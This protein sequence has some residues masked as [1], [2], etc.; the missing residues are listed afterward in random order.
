[1]TNCNTEIFFFVDEL[2]KTLEK[3]PIWE[4][5]PKWNP[6]RK[7]RKK[8]L[9]LSEVVTLN[10]IA[11][12]GHFTDLKAFHRNAQLYLTNDFPKLTNYENYLKATNKSLPFL[13]IILKLLLDISKYYSKNS[14]KYVDSTPLQVCKNKRISRNRVCKNFAARGKSTIGWFYGF[15]L[16]GVC[17]SNGT[18]LSITFT[19]GNID[20]RKVL[21]SLFEGMDGLFVGDAGY[22]LRFDLWNEFL[23]KNIHVFTGVRNNMKKI[24]TKEQ[25]KELKKRE[26]IE[27][28]WSVMKGN[29]SIIYTLAR[30]ITGMFRHFFYSVIAYFFR[31][32]NNEQIFIGVT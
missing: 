1:M 4:Q 22:L 7:G 13:L 17:D 16:H 21:H 32:I 15:K 11:V 8:R 9:S 23:E 28:V 26:I 19:P 14:T 5:L 2:L 29:L 31:H 20:D 18:L 3:T 27:T 25:H 12:L 30:S 10:I 24:M 6:Y